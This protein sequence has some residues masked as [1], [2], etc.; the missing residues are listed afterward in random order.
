[1]TDG[2]VGVQNPRQLETNEGAAG[3][4]KFYTERPF[5]YLGKKKQNLLHQNQEMNLINFV[6]LF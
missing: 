6:T 3:F 1:M 2:A 4:P 5:L